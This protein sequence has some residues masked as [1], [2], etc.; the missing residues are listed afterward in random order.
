LAATFFFFFFIGVAVFLA[1]FFF[2]D[3]TD[4]FATAFLG[5]EAF[6]FFV[7]FGITILFPGK[8]LFL[9]PPAFS[10]LFYFTILTDK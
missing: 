2:F 7:V 8:R 9:C 10:I 5:F 3:V 1:T 4:F 6:F